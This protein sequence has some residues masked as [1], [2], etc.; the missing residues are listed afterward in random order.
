MPI[1]NVSNT[2]AGEKGPGGGG[3]TTFR[4]PW[5]K[6][7]G[8]PAIPMPKAPWSKR[9]SLTPVDPP[10]PTKDNGQT[11][12]KEVK[13]Q[14]KE[15]KVPIMTAIKKTPAA[16][17]QSNSSS[18]TKELEK[19][20]TPVEKPDSSEEVKTTLKKFIKP[21]ETDIEKPKV[22]DKKL[23]TDKP[24]VAG[25]IEKPGKFVRPVLKKVAKVEVAPIPPK[26]PPLKSAIKESIKIVE[27]DS[28]ESE[29]ETSEEETET[30]TETETESE[31]EEEDTKK[32]NKSK[33]K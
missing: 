3:R 2:S 12:P 16:Q 20:T 8:P 22:D 24:K 25:A 4:P 21:K 23:D 10:Q 5:V 11:A 27:D 6:D 31:S 28:E 9:Q 13:L 29:E 19:K 7:G 15:V 26:Q 18:K 30:E 14:S 32:T 1:T 17:M 33:Y